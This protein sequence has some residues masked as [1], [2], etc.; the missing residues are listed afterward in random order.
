M[1]RV[2]SAS[3]ADDSAN[4]EGYSTSHTASEFAVQVARLA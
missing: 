3:D 2:Q 1:Q 4:A